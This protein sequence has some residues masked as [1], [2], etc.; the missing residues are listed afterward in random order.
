MVKPAGPVDCDVCLLPMLSITHDSST[1]LTWAQQTRKRWIL[2]YV[3]ALRTSLHLLELDVVIAVVLCHFFSSGLVW[4]LQWHNSKKHRR[5]VV[6]HAN[7]VGFHGMS[8]AIIIIPNAMSRR[9]A[10][11]QRR[12]C[13][14]RQPRSVGRSALRRKNRGRKEGGGVGGV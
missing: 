7:S 8:L 10:S 2:D 13:G 4:P 1:Y 3:N 12:R 14:G 9:V 11:L 6:G 5:Q